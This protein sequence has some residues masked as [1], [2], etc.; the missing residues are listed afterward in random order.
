MARQPAEVAPQDTTHLT[1]Q[2]C[3]G[4]EMTHRLHSHPQLEL[5]WIRRSE[6]TR[7][8]GNNVD[9]FSAN[10]ILL[11]GSN[12]PHAFVHK[13]KPASAG[14]QLREEMLVIRFDD[15]FLGDTFLS[16]PEM[17]DVRNLFTMAAQ[18]ILVTEQGKKALI[19]LL[20]K[21]A[22]SEG[23]ERVMLLLT[24]FRNLTEKGNFRV[25]VNE[26]FIFQERMDY[27]NRISKIIDYTARN[28][29][30]S[31]KIDEVADMVSLTKESF[32][33]YFRSQ[34]HKTYKIF[35]ME[36][37]IRQACRMLTENKKSISE[38]GSC[39]GYE[40]LSNFYHQFKKIVKQSPLEYK[41]R[42][43]QLTGKYS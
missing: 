11:I 4:E 5:V 32:C 13:E 26:G 31:I 12:T 25:L 2:W 8:I 38:I 33:R 41:S 40:N 9:D 10:E 43:L 18:G 17:S 37:R 21:I 1:V 3:R 30:Q 15:R 7:I 22:A 39:C 29:H 28:Y 23:F 27:D 20:G 35:L 34:T 14:G 24:V 19:P 36:F 6:G 16:L 42:Y